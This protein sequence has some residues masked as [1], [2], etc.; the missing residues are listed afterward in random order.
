MGVIYFTKRQKLNDLNSEMIF[1]KEK[2]SDDGMVLT[3][4]ERPDLNCPLQCTFRNSKYAWGAK[5][6]YLIGEIFHSNHSPGL[7]NQPRHHVSINP[8]L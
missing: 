3:D 2:K 1:V 4:A 8:D 7:V 5:G 6:A